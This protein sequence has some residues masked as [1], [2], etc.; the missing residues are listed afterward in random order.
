M[1]TRG[2]YTSR[3]RRRQQQG[4]TDQRALIGE[5][6]EPRRL[7]AADPWVDLRVTAT[8]LQ[9]APLQQIGAGQDF[10]VEVAVSDLRSHGLPGVFA[11][12]L[13]MEFDPGVA[14]P[15]ADP[16]NPYGF[17][18]Q[19]GSDYG[20]G[21]SGQVTNGLLDEIGGFQ[22]GLGPLGHIYFDL[23]KIRM[24]A[25]GV[26]LANDVFRNVPEDSPQITLD[27]LQND[28][29]HSFIPSSTSRATNPWAS[30]AICASSPS[31]ARSR[32]AGSHFRLHSNG[33]RWPPRPC[34]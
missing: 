7:L 20:N 21:H 15:V 9:G 17:D 29:I 22:S 31:Q 19:F 26:S 1:R 28:Q 12:Y 8:D 6:L 5:A 32:S 30:P 23:F 33:R 25:Q 13:D 16:T 2:K 24:T 10:Y 34:I 3:Q 4:R 27:V 11:A 18:L 14:Q